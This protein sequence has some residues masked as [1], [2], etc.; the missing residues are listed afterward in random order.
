MMKVLPTQTRRRQVIWDL[1][2]LEQDVDYLAQQMMVNYHILP[3]DFYN[4][5]FSDYI[6]AQNAQSR[7][8]RPGR[9]SDFIESL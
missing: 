5:S 4:S 3:T 6:E 8:K 7:E 2:Q 1:Y 9:V